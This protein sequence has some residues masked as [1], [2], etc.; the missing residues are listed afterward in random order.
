MAVWDRFGME[1]VVVETLGCLY[2][3][4]TNEDFLLGRVGTHGFY[5]SACSGHGFKFGPWI[6]R[7]LADFV[8]G[9]DSP[10]RY[11]RFCVHG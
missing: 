3:S 7:L 5:A 10:D 9:R 2:T 11:E 1:P 6:G 4:T 8:E